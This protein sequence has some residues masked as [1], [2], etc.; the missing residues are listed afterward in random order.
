MELGKRDIKALAIDLDG[1]VYYGEECEQ[2]DKAYNTASIEF[3]SK[4]LGME[5]SSVKAN[6][7]QM[8]KK[9]GSSSYGLKLGYGV[10]PREYQEWIQNKIDYSIL[11]PNPTL[12]HILSQVHVPIYIFTSNLERIAKKVIRYVGI[13]N[14]ISGIFDIA[15]AEYKPKSMTETYEKMLRHFGIAGARDIM[16]CDDIHA[17]LRPAHQLG[18]KTAWVRSGSVRSKSEP[19]FPLNYDEANILDVLH[20]TI[21]DG[22]IAT[23]PP[24]AQTEKKLVSVG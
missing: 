4:H 8:L 5:P 20:K 24:V 19:E 10:E 7:D 21:S 14:H 12:A 1:T 22:T 18:A 13:E 15:L 2:I 11:K 6:L 16:M 9:Y 23:K 17:N 3:C